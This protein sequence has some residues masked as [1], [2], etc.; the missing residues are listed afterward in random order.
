MVQTLK[1]K[2]TSFDLAIL[3]Q[4]SIYFDNFQT[5]SSIDIGTSNMTIKLKW[6][7]RIKYVVKKSYNSGI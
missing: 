1:V 6:L 7:L 3:Y 2:K 4:K 5:Q